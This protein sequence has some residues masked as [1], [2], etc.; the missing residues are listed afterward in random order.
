MTWNYSMSTPE[1]VFWKLKHSL[2][3]A[4]FSC[5]PL[6][7]KSAYTPS[8]N[9]LSSRGKRDQGG[10]GKAVTVIH[11]TSQSY[12]PEMPIVVTRTRDR[13]SQE[14]DEWHSQRDPSS[15]IR[16]KSAHHLIKDAVRYVDIKDKMF[17]SFVNTFAFILE[18]SHISAQN[19]TI[20]Q[21]RAVTCVYTW[22]DTIQSCVSKKLLET[23]SKYRRML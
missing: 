23:H 10:G 17:H 7:K 9:G 3:I 14:M 11:Y 18:K 13:L 12:P 6:N 2:L 21:L 15:R 20:A 8:D 4:T 16:M 22:R 19:V 1:I 5:C